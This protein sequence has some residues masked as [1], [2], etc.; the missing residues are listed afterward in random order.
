MYNDNAFTP[1]GF[2]QL[3]HYRV[4]T[5]YRP[6]TWATVSGAFNDLERHN[7][8]NNNQNFPG[9]TTPY[10][11]PL[12]H[13]DHS[14]VVSFG[15]ELFPNDHYGLDLN[16]SYNDVYMADNICFQGAASVMP[17]GTVAPAAANPE[18]YAL[19]PRRSRP[20]IEYRPL[21]ASQGFRGR[22]DAVR[23]GRLHVRA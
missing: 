21:R 14:R 20:W 11:G 10:F 2:R 13:V 4:H 23:L 19:R 5:I 18:R 9:N 22:S 17:G 3:R 8:T 15:A 12:D 6:K 7:N 1:M 16:Y